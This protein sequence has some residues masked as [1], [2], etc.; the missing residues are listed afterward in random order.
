MP[1]DDEEYIIPY[2]LPSRKLARSSAARLKRRARSRTATST[3]IRRRESKRDT[4]AGVGARR[5]G[6]VAIGAAGRKGRNGRAP[7]AGAGNI[8]RPSQR[9]RATPARRSEAAITVVSR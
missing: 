6:L 9:A 7:W 4:I 1:Y 8:Q 3:P 2:A 5:C